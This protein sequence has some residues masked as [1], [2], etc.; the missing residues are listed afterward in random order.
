MWRGAAWGFFFFVAGG[1]AWLFRNGHEYMFALW[2][3]MC[4]DGSEVMM[5]KPEVVL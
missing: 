5:K 3:G 2:G 4:Y 1:R